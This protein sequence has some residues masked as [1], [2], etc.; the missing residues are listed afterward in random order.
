MAGKGGTS[1]AGWVRGRWGNG[2]GGTGAAVFSGGRAGVK[3]KNPPAFLSPAACL[4]AG[5][6]MG[7]VGGWQAARGAAGQANRAMEPAGLGRWVPS[8]R[9][10]L[11]VLSP[12]PTGRQLPAPSRLTRGRISPWPLAHLRA[13]NHADVGGKKTGIGATRGFAGLSQI[14]FPSGG[15]RARGDNGA[16][17]PSPPARFAPSSLGLQR[18]TAAPGLAFTSSSSKPRSCGVGK[19]ADNGVC[20]LGFGR[21]RCPNTPCPFALRPPPPLQGIQS[22]CVGG[23]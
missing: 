13:G 12:N 20:E 15:A 16:S 18:L 9:G 7:L 11:R 10:K 1:G 23:G 5:L 19:L 6:A 2:G 3:P 4:E 14:K 21:P 8:S 17:E 22:G